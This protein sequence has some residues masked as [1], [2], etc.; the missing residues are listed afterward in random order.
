MGKA[1]KHSMIG[2]LVG[3]VLSE[4]ALN[5]LQTMNGMQLNP[6]FRVAIDLMAYSAFSALSSAYSLFKEQIR[7]IKKEELRIGF[8][9]HI[10]VMGNALVP[11]FIGAYHMYQHL[12][13]PVYIK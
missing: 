4:S 10:N 2:G 9:D 3:L 7:V 12:W 11:G 8:N 1:T 6:N 13:Q 5:V